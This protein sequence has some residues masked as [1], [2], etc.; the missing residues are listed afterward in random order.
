M[1]SG[2]IVLVGKPNVGKSTLL[3]V[4]L[5]K[6]LAIISPKPQTTVY[7]VK[8]VATIG[9][10]KVLCVDTPGIHKYIH[11]DRNRAMNRL[12]HYAMQSHDI[13]L[14][15]FKAGSWEAEDANI[16]EWLKDVEAPKIAVITHIDTV[17]AYALE[18]TMDKLRD[19]SFQS[20]V[21]ICAIKNTFMDILNASIICL[22]PEEKNPEDIDNNNHS[23]GFLAQEM[24]REQLMNLLH[25]E[26][27][28][29][30]SIEILDIKQTEEKLIIHA[31]LIVTKANH[32]KIL[33]GHRGDMIKNIGMNARKRIQELLEHG[34]E[35]RLW[36]QCKERRR[37]YDIHE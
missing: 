25:Q 21:P 19:L 29:A 35:L 23:D 32:K 9:N 31:N 3:N 4:L 26:I 15:L 20:I 27:P 6:P 13:V 34:V 36:V 33:V 37:N 11:Q 18:T 30:V 28:Y 1:F 14:C 24:I 17:D 22:L 10:H 8:G 7:L 2:S 12:A 5:H 16:I